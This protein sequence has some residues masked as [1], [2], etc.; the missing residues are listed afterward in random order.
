M[1]RRLDPD[2][3][4]P[5]YG[6][7]S[8]TY[9]DVGHPGPA[10]RPRGLGQEPGT[11][12]QLRSRA[13]RHR[14]TASTRA[15][16]TAARS[17][18][19]SRASTAAGRGQ[20]HACA[21]S[22][23]RRRA[24]PGHSEFLGTGGS[25]YYLRHTDC[26]AGFGPGGA[27]GARPDH[28]PRRDADTSA[29]R[30]RLRDRRAAGPHAVDAPAGADRARQPAYHHPR[31]AAGRFRQAACWW[32]T[33]TCRAAFSADQPHRRASAASTWLGDHVAIGGTYVDE[34]ARADDYS[35]AAL[36]LTLQAGP[37]HLPEDRAVA[38]QR[39]HRCSGIL[40]RPMAASASPSA[41]LPGG[42]RSG[43]A[44]SVEARANFKELGW[45]SKEWTASAWW[46]DIDRRLLDLHA[47]TPAW[48]FTNRARNCSGEFSES[49]KLY[50][51]YSKAEHG[52][53]SLEQGNVTADLAHQRQ[54]CA[55]RRAAPCRPVAVGPVGYVVTCL[56]WVTP[57]DSAATSMCTASASTR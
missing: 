7:D 33:N 56:R 42:P 20:A 54:R 31:H 14:A 4:Y 19:R 18:W 13:H 1:F 49:F 21:H 57:S 10:V 47:T 12:G 29:R 8:T 22:V 2:Q 28:R 5:V 55:D 52:A 48:P 27:G 37:R 16:F 53:D 40:L 35:L 30:C 38:V 6:D 45:T 3:Y 17:S 41:I 24:R 11:V 23:R 43:D 46:R 25:L 15:A 9:R 50:S 26:A 44:S 51:R 39:S 36:D 32:I 34:S